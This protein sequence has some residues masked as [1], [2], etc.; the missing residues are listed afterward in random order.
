MNRLPDSIERL[1]PDGTFERVAVRRLLAGDVVRVQ[2]GESFAA[3]GVIE[4]GTTMVDEALLTGESRP[5]ARKP[6]DTVVAGSHNLNSTVRVKL[7]RV[8]ADTR[9]AQIVALMESAS[10]SKPQVAMMADRLAKPFLI[11]VLLAAAA[12]CAWWW[13]RDPGHALMVAVAV[14]VVTCPCALSLATPAAMLAAAGALARSGTMVRN[15]QALETLSK[16]D[17]L[18]FDKTGTV[19]RDAMVIGQIRVRD[20]IQA[21]Q[22]LAMATA[23]ARHSMH[24]VSVAL[25]LAGNALPSEAHWVCDGVT[26]SAGQGVAGE[27]RLPGQP[28]DVLRLGLRLWSQKDRRFRHHQRGYPDRRALA[29]DNRENWNRSDGAT[30]SRATAPGLRATAGLHRQ[31]GR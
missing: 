29:Q 2:P 3:D 10:S 5:L 8:G 4:S 16:V 30:G 9:F 26:E 31:G 17:T 1:K 28:A 23:L 27:M 15:L 12:S 11:G 21:P 19:T 20:G 14:L 25:T 18:V 22:A 13:S 7:E 24:P 6:G